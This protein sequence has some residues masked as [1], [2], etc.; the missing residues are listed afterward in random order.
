MNLRGRGMFNANIDGLKLLGIVGYR[1]KRVAN[2]I[3]K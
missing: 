2:F 3:K 1:E